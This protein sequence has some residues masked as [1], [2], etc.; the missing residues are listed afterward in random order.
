MPPGGLPGYPPGG[1]PGYP[2]LQ[3]GGRPGAPTRFAADDA[4]ERIVAQRLR[5]LAYPYPGDTWLEEVAPAELTLKLRAVA[6]AQRKE[7]EEG[8]EEEA[9]SGKEK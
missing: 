2:R 5:A 1:L 9:E 6:S 4:S 3:P 8:V 7:E